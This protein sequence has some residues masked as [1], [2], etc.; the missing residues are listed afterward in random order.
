MT[1]NIL[2]SPFR[3]NG[4]ELKNHLVMAPMTR[5]RAID[6]LPNHLMAEYYGQRTGAGLIITEG[7]SPAPEGLGYPRIPGLFSA[8]Q[9]EGWKK[10]TKRVHEGNSKIFVQLMHTGRIGHEDNLPR[11]SHLVSAAA[12][13]AAGQIFTDTKGLQDHSVPQALTTDGVKKVIASHAAAARNAMGA[14]FDGIELHG[15]NGYLIEQFLNPNLNNRDDEFGGSIEAR[16]KF[17]TDLAE[18]VG[19]SIGYNKIGVR[20]S[21]YS[22]MGD[23]SAY[24]DEE[25]KETYVSLAKELGKLGIAYLHIALS[26][27]V[28]EDFL[29][30]LKSAFGGIII[31]C[32]GLNPASAERHLEQGTADLTAFGRSFLANPDFTERILENSALNQPDTSTFYTP[33]SKGYIDYKQMQELL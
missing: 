27:A 28:K 31:I 14:G 7:T 21:P 6:N 29:K 4:L 12:V 19:D 18:Q 20:F 22:T 11:G 33:G 10:V 23:L 32:N 24:P 3:K 26:P 13:K 5:S 1:R 9:I 2:L 15:A 8:E 30:T 16:I 25:V 17:V